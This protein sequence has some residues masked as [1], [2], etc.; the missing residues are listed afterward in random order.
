MA[1]TVIRERGFRLFF[2]SREET[3]PHIHVH[4]SGVESKFWL[5]P[6][7]ALA[8]NYGLSSKQLREADDPMSNLSATLGSSTSGPE[9]THISPHGI[10]LLV[11]DRELFLPFEQ[12][13]WFRKASVDAIQN[14]EQPHARHL[15]WPRLDVDLAIDSIENPEHYPLVS[16]A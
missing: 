4:H 14:V 16:D 15:Y 1:P 3:R 7:V 9:V 8:Q 2:F 6:E 10:W 11:E 13:P 5:E 12:F